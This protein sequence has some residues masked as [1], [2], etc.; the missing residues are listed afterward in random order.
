MHSSWCAFAASSRSPAANRC[1][2]CAAAAWNVYPRKIKAEPGFMI[3]ATASTNSGFAVVVPKLAAGM[4]NVSPFSVVKSD[5]AK[6][7]FSCRRQ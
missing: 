4:I 6:K 3:V 7:I 5:T 1:S 2:A